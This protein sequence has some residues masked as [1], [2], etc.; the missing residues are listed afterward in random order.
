MPKFKTKNKRKRPRARL[1]H[2]LVRYQSTCR[3]HKQQMAAWLLP[4]SISHQPLLWFPDYA[5]NT[6]CYRV[7][8]LRFLS[9][10]N[11]YTDVSFPSGY[12]DP[13]HTDPHRACPVGES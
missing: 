10:F 4:V 5:A 6:R 1:S 12:T 13:L 11:A 2:F 8:I 7:T 3:L 9:V